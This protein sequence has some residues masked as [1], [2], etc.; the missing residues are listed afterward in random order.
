MRKLKR[1]KLRKK[2][3]NKNLKLAWE[4]YQKKKYGKDYRKICKPKEA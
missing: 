3:G 1:D 4:N 2:V